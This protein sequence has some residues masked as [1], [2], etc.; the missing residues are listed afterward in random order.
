MACVALPI[1]ALEEEANVALPTIVQAAVA[2]AEHRTIVRGKAL[3]ERANVVLPIIVQAAVANAEPRTIVRGK[4]LVEKANVVLP[5]IALVVEANA[6]LRT[7]VQE[8]EVSVEHHIIVQ[9][10]EKNSFTISI[11]TRD[12]Q[13]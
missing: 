3:V 1:T 5:I 8:V 12:L 2:N 11:Y 6:E 7:I 9:D 4:A 13:G 10:N